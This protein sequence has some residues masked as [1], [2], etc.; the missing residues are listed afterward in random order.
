MV[1]LTQHAFFG[2]DEIK[3]IQKPDAKPRRQRERKLVGT[4]LQLGA[5]RQSSAIAE[6]IVEGDLPRVDVVCFAD[7]G[8]EPAWVYEQVWHLAGRLDSVGI[9]LIITMKKDFSGGIVESA[10]SNPARYAS[11]PVFTGQHGQ[12]GGMLRR[13]CTNDWKVQPADDYIRDWL[14]ERGHVTRAKNGSRRVKPSVYVEMWYG[15][16]TD[17]MYRQKKRGTG[18]Q[19]AVYPL[20]TLKMNTRDCLAYLKEK[21]LPVPR[22]SSCRI[23]PYHEDE[24]WLDLQQ[25]YPAD[26]EHACQFDD[27]I[28]T[29]HGKRATFKHIKDKLYLHRSCTPLREV[30]FAARIE[31]KRR[32]NVSPFQKELILQGSCSTDGGFSCFS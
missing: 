5:G 22:K 13:Q 18:W 10:K 3:I 8:D 6:M 23:C 31:V 1:T 17:E 26:F 29:L 21:G 7:T 19:Q 12:P 2:I 15:I 20:I 4:V 25:N 11:M 9:P 16:G 32:G 28:R 30:D 24:Y 14:E 27:F